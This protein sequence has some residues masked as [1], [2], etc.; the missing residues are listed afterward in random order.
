[1]RHLFG[2]GTPKQ[3]AAAVE[4][5]FMALLGVHQMVLETRHRAFQALRVV[6]QSVAIFFTTF[7]PSRTSLKARAEN[8]TISTAAKQEPTLRVS[9]VVVALAG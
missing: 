6:T 2:I 8:L 9:V 3:A 1:M 5:G 7:F 4:M